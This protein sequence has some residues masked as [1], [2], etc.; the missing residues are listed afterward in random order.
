MAT[1][2]IWALVIV[3]E[4]F[5]FGG[6]DF[7]NAIYYSSRDMCVKNETKI[8]KELRGYNYTEVKAHCMPILTKQGQN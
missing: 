7:E 6:P 2:S 8:N 3:L 1:I 4:G 5:Y